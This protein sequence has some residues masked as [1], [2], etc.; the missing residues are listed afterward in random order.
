MQISTIAIIAFAANAAA[1]TASST[2]LE[3]VAKYSNSTATSWTIPTTT[4]TITSCESG[5]TDCI[6]GTDY[7]NS[8][9]V[10]TTVQTFCTTE[11]ITYCPPEVTSCPINGTHTSLT[12]YNITTTATVTYC[13]TDIDC[14]TEIVCPT[15]IDCL[16]IVSPTVA[17]KVNP[18]N[19]AKPANSAN[20]A[21]PANPANSGKPVNPANSVSPVNSVKSVSPVN[22]VNSSSSNPAKISTFLAGANKQFAAG[23]VALAAGVL[24]GM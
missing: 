22:Q 14:F 12:T 15:G 8:T 21:N 19:P 17:P 24:M 1:D 7:K 5:A 23:F 11:T 3:P 20:S 10:Y 2:T 16:T 13:P 9:S 6:T 4:A 18:A